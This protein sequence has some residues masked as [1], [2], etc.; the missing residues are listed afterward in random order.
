ML[1]LVDLFATHALIELSLRSDCVYAKGV[2]TIA[3]L[4]PD[5]RAISKRIRNQ[6]EGLQPTRLRTL[7]TAAPE[8]RFTVQTGPAAMAARKCQR[9]TPR[10]CLRCLG[11]HSRRALGSGDARNIDDVGIHHTSKWRL[12]AS[13]QQCGD[14][15]GA[16]V[17]W[18]SGR[19]GRWVSE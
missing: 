7:P 2:K 18:N 1:Q 6:H 9:I 14:V 3:P 12:S 8:W 11:V 4:Y 13:W 17:S 15:E 19:G 10:R 16:S 5:S